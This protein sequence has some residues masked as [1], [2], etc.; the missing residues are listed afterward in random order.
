MQTRPLPSPYARWDIQVTQGEEF[1]MAKGVAHVQIITKFLAT[2]NSE[3]ECR[4]GLSLPGA[5]AALSDSSVEEAG[6][7]VTMTTSLSLLV[8]FAAT[9]SAALIV[10]HKKKGQQSAEILGESEKMTSANPLYKSKASANG[11]E[12]ERE[13]MVVSNIKGSLA[14]IETALLD[15]KEDM[16]KAL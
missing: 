1:L 16:D 12:R 4:G 8:V 2:V 3:M 9:A 14:S 7:D 13:S 5:S 15:F 11:E 10:R 6:I